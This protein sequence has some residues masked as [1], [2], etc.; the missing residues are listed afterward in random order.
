MLR[1]DPV[2]IVGVAVPRVAKH[3]PDETATSLTLKSILAAL[4]DAG[5]EP[6]DV[7]GMC[8]TWPGP[9]GSHQAWSTNWARQLG[10]TLNWVI[11][12]GLDVGGIRG[13][14]N[15]AAAIKAGLCETVVVATATAGG[16]PQSGRDRMAAIHHGGPQFVS[17]A[18]SSDGH[19]D[20]THAALEFNH[21]Y[22]GSGAIHR[23]A[24]NAMRH[25]HDYGTTHEQIAEVA[26]TIRNNGYRNPEAMHFG[27]GPFTVEDILA[28]RWIAEPLHLLECSLVGQCGVAVV[29]TSGERARNLKRPPVYVLAGAMEMD[30]GPHHNPALNRVNGNL[31]GDRMKVAYS[32][33]GI[34]PGDIDVLSVYDPTAFEVIRNLEM[35][36]FCR[37]GEGGPFVESGAIALGGKIPTN[38]DGGLLSH[39]WSTM[40][41]LLLKV[42]EGARQLRGDCGDR[43][44][45]AAELAV[46]TNS[47][48]G[49]HHVEALI[50]G[51]RA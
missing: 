26:A 20:V 51:S 22:G 17:G 25:M 9:G 47:V 19:G 33:V 44:V 50:L 30:D 32:Q 29:L 27:R 21:P 16:P 5:L 48:P 4:D 8:A 12:E 31:G 43:Q 14:L 7:N 40:G 3:I 13:V 49:A 1:D 45:E 34:T 41:Q 2:A 42:I 24:L 10:V 46:C 18:T 36:G 28:S 15:A 35:L 6:S 39:A 38:T 37:P 23:F 11:D